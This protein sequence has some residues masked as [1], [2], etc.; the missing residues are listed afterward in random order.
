MF[1]H[2]EQGSVD[3]RGGL[4]RNWRNISGFHH[5]EG[6]LAA[7]KSHDWLP[8]VVVSSPLGPDEVE[9][10]TDT[11]ITADDVTDTVNKR[12]MTAQEITDRDQAIE[13]AKTA[14]AA[15]IFNDDQFVAFIKVCADQFGM[16]GT[17]MKAAI[18][19]KL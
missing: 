9:T 6:D 13:D 17:Q 14:R 16:N 7:L 10:T 11:V 5:L 8:L 15:S 12:A 19:A 18:R 1:A 3:Y 4:P 2:V